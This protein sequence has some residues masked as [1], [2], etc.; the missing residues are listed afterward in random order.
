MGA[1]VLAA[2][3]EKPADTVPPVVNNAVMCEGVQDGRP[4][5]QSIVFAVSNTSVYCWSDFDPVTEDGFIYHEW[6]R[7]G[8]LITRKKLAVHA[9]RWATFSSLPLRQADIGPWHLNI[10]DETG[11]VLKTLRFSI[12][13]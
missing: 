10:T 2:Q 7:K 6:Y 8:V 5:N 12:T 11:N 4:V 13:E 3:A 1:T 9:P